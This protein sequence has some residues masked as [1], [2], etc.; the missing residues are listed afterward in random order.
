MSDTK[1]TSNR[2]KR[3]KLAKGRAVKLPGI[4]VEITDENLNNAAVMKIITR[5]EAN[6]GNQYF[7]K[8][9]IEA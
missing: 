8:V 9:F 1:P 5:A 3:Y 4:S 2:T 6:T 7:G